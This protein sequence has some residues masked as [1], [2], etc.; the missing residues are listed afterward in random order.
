MANVKTNQELIDMWLNKLEYMNNRSP[1]TIKVYRGH[2]VSFSSLIN[3]P[4]SEVDCFDI[5]LFLSKKN[6]KSTYKQIKQTIICNFFNWMYDHKFCE[7]HPKLEREGFSKETRNPKFLEKEQWEIVK[8]YLQNETTNKFLVSSSSVGIDKKVDKIVQ[9]KADNITEAKK[10]FAKRYKLDYLNYVKAEPI[11]D[12]FTKDRN[13]MVVYFMINSGLRS[14]EVLELTVDKINFDRQEITVIGKKDKERIVQINKFVVRELKEY[15]DKYKLTK[16]VFPN[17]NKEIWA[18]KS[19][20]YVFTTI[21]KKTG[22]SFN[23]HMTRHT[24]GQWEYDRGMKLEYIQQ[25]MGHDSID[26]TK[27]YVRVRN[28]QVKDAVNQ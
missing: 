19:F 7:R 9:I 17:E 11:T 15:I 14:F 13:Y 12:I 25:Q 28:Q 3:K 20:D 8:N 6:E 16:Y 18:K 27:I 24:Y 23:P 22:I 21:T 1:K 5:E 2:L 10:I 26:T 4:F